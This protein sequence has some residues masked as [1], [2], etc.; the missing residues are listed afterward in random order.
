MHRLS[1]ACLILILLLAPAVIFAG[2]PSGAFPSLEAQVTSN[3]E[4]GMDRDTVMGRL[5]EWCDPGNPQMRKGMEMVLA[6]EGETNHAL[7]L[8]LHLLNKGCYTPGD[9][10]PLALALA[11][12]RLYSLVSQPVRDEIKKDIVRHYSLYR[13]IV[14]WQKESFEISVDLSRMPLVPQIYWADRMA[15]PPEDIAYPIRT[16]DDYREYIDSIETLEFFH[17]Q[18][19]KYRLFEG[20]SMKRIGK[21]VSSYVFGKDESGY[22][23]HLYNPSEETV[24]K[25]LCNIPHDPG[26]RTGLEW[27][28][29]R[30]KG[31]KRNICD[32]IWTNYQRLTMERTGHSVGLCEASSCIEVAAFK[33]L[34]IPAGFM[35]RLPPKERPFPGHVF[36]MYYDPNRRRWLNLEMIRSWD[37]SQVTELV[38]NKPVWHHRVS[39]LQQ[40]VREKAPANR[41]F[42]VLDFGI[43]RELL[44]KAFFAN[45]QELSDT[46]FGQ[47]SLPGD[48]V[49]TDMDGI[50]DFEERM[51]GTDP[52]RPDTA[53]DGVS[54]MWKLDHGYDPKEPVT[55]GALKLPPLDGLGGGYADS[56]R[57]TSVTVNRADG[58]P[59]PDVP[60]INT[61]SA[62]RFGDTVY[63]HVTF[64]NDIRKCTRRDNY[65]W[66]GL[67]GGNGRVKGFDMVVDGSGIGQNG[68]T[69]AQEPDGYRDLRGLSI[70]DV[71]LMI[72]VRYFDG[73]ESTKIVFFTARV[74]GEMTLDIR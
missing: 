29:F 52:A 66:F 38:I 4:A 70:T 14:A 7:R 74:R 61:M 18:A 60:E 10:M 33:G 37:T 54:D 50:P 32:F 5:V 45:R 73:A 24:Q 21:G 62:A 63:V 19:V 41:F 58:N 13:K 57:L 35:I 55:D 22:A 15:Y 23:R 51:L 8:L 68:G 67:E 46:L 43:T 72:P 47:A 39:G 1:H 27:F 36:S 2:D 31:V 26:P 16:L 59:Q 40:K 3:I 71:E 53:G 34:G 12:N 11:N 65:I 17:N 56:G 20:Q 48:P 25:L 69:R 42:R 49:D 64:H 9:T 6:G 44:E 28:Q 30:Y